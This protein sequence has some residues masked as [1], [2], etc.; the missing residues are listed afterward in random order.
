M[1]QLELTSIKIEDFRGTKSLELQLDGKDTIVRGA[2][3]TGKTT[4]L[5]AYLWCLTGKDSQGRTDCEIKRREDGETLP[6]VDASVTVVLRVDGEPWTLKRTLHEKWQKP[7]GTTEEQFKGN[8]TLTEVNGVPTSVTEYSQQVGALIPYD[9]IITLT[10]AG[11]FFAQPWQD[12]RTQLIEMTG[13]SREEIE[14]AVVASDARFAKLLDKLTGKTLDGYRREILASKRKTRTELDGIQPRIDQTEKLKPE[15]GDKTALLGERAKV[16]YKLTKLRASERSRLDSNQAH[17][18]ERKTLLARI[19]D[20]ELEQQQIVRKA[21]AERAN[22]QKQIANSQDEQYNALLKEI[23]KWKQSLLRNQD[24]LSATKEEQA[25]A[26]Q[27][28]DRI[29]ESVENLRLA[30]TRTASEQYD[31][32]ELCPTCHQPLP[33]ERQEEAR[34]R[35]HKERT[36]RLERIA[37]DGKESKALADSQKAEIARLHKRIEELDA[38]VQEATKQVLAHDSQRKKLE[39]ARQEAEAVRQEQIAKLQAEPLLLPNRYHDIDGEIKETQAKLEELAGRTEEQEDE[40]TKAEIAKQE[41]EMSRIQKLIDDC[42]RRDELD[43]EIKRLHSVGRDLAQTLADLEAM[44]QVITDY[45]QAVVQAYEGRIGDLFPTLRF[46]LFDYTQ[47]GDRYE[48]CIPL[49]GDAHYDTANTASRINAG[50]E[51]HNAL[52]QHLGLTAPLIVDNRESVTELTAHSGQVI[53]LMV[54]PTAKELTTA[55][56]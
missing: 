45:S 44:E 5:D 30:Y 9:R 51:L 33:E 25:Q 12:M 2:N 22:S 34:Q 48:T 50:I 53:S 55:S 24:D 37:R 39:S 6:K 14:Q 56:K 52:A 19:S 8:E 36:E 40:A 35:W 46:A 16:E 7:R 15:E 38:N 31:G 32:T 17:L 43:K 11:Y 41:E 10:M 23:S 21:E 13:V 20:L 3:G 18:D 26:S 29:N 49:I 4:I 47:A 42:D 27:R 54:D 1:K 28:L